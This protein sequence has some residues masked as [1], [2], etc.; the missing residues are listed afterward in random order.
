MLRLIFESKLSIHAK[1]ILYKSLLK[2]TWACSMQTWGCAK[3]SQ[4]QTTQSFQSI[5]LRLIASAPWYVTNKALHK[6]TQDLKI[7]Q[8]EK[9]YY[10]KFHLKL[11]HHPNS[12]ISHVSSR[13][14]PE[15]PHRHLKKTMV[16]RP[17]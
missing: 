13:T 11:Q 17:P 9:Q 8:L 12:F 4:T 6:T 10:R 15:N 16:P 2:P 14:L 1:S 3:P 5:S 7:D